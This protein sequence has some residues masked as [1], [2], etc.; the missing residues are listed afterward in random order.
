MSTTQKKHKKQKAAEG[1]IIWFNPSYSCNVATD[2]SK[3][4]LF[5]NISLRHTCTKVIQMNEF[6]NKTLPHYT[7]LTTNKNVH[8]KTLLNVTESKRNATQ[9]SNFIWD[10]KKKKMTSH[11]NGVY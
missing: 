1:A 4:F 2:I 11:S 3:K 8:I 7:R 9:F 5:L 6:T 10:R